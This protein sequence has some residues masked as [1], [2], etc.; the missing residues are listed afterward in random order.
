MEGEFFAGQLETNGT[1]DLQNDQQF[2]DQQNHNSTGFPVDGSHQQQ[3]DVQMGAD[4]PAGVMH[5]ETS[6]PPPPDGSIALP[7]PPVNEV[8]PSSTEA[9]PP[10]P[11]LGDLPLPPPPARR[12]RWGAAQ[13]EDAAGAGE[14][15]K[16]KK[17]RSRW[18]EPE[19]SNAIVV[20]APTGCLVSTFT[21]PK[22]VTLSNGMKVGFFVT[23]PVCDLD[24]SRT[25]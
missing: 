17:K 13:G 18:E 8:P 21:F 20:A 11:A 15:E 16:K 10:P 19:P 22:E 24:Q 1:A 3:H 7:P 12:Q 14:G 4:E 6:F 5:V 25:T 2:P 9:L 23:A